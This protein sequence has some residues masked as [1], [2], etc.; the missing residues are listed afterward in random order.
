M[1][2]GRG[3]RPNLQA[4]AISRLARQRNSCARRAARPSILDQQLV[5]LPVD[6][7]A[8]CEEEIVRD[9][10]VAAPP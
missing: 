2:A 10:R 4:H 6:G 8:M 5:G 7:D 3:G 1:E 9:Q